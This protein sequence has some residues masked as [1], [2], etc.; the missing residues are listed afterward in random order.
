MHLYGWFKRNMKWE[1]RERLVSGPLN[2]KTLFHQGCWRNGSGFTE[3]QEVHNPG[4]LQGHLCHG[5]AGRLHQYQNYCLCFKPTL[6]YLHWDAEPM[7]L[8]TH[9]PF[10][11][12]FLLGSARRGCQRETGE[13]ENFPPIPVNVRLTHSSEFTSSQWIHFWFLQPVQLSCKPSETPAQ[14][15]GTLFFC[16]LGTTLRGP[17]ASSELLAWVTQQSPPECLSLCAQGPSSRLLSFHIPSSSFYSSNLAGN[18]FL[19]LLLWDIPVSPVSSWL[20][21]TWLTAQYYTPSPRAT[22]VH[23]LST[24]PTYGQAGGEAGQASFPRCVLWT[25][26]TS[27]CDLLCDLILNQL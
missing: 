21:N 1:L 16:N 5:C 19:H 15:A 18:H 25:Q 11:G 23:L 14:E 22:G 27:S 20:P 2:V 17:S 24:G 3:E 4:L 12:S 26:K 9:F 13:P 8:L 10:A 6:S 7:S